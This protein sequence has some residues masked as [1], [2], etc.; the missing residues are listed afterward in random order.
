VCVCVCACVNRIFQPPPDVR[1]HSLWAGD[2]LQANW[3]NSEQLWVLFPVWPSWRFVQAYRLLRCF[4]ESPPL[5]APAAVQPSSSPMSLTRTS[6]A[7]AAT[8]ISGRHL[9]AEGLRCCCG[10]GVMLLYCCWYSDVAVLVPCC[11]YVGILQC[12]AGLRHA[13]A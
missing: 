4:A 2:F 1:D 12:R 9:G 8:V 6:N 7:L 3:R 13:G 11:G 10:F 5:H